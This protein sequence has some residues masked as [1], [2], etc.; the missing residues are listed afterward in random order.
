MKYGVMIYESTSNIG[1]DIQSYAA[2]RFLPRIDTVIDR[3]KMDGFCLRNKVDE[4][5]TVIMNGWYMHRK[6]N[7]PPSPLINPLYLSMHITEYD[8]LDIGYRF[9]D[10][11]GGDYLRQFEPIGARDE[12]TLA[13]LKEKGIEAYLSGCL[14]LTLALPD[15]GERG[16]EVILTDVNKADAAALIKQFPNENWQ[17]VSHTID[18]EATRQKSL[19]ERFEAV[20]ALLKRYQRAKCV[21]TERLHCALPCLALGTPVLLL[22][23]NDNLDRMS[24]FLPLLHN[25]RIGE[26]DACSTVFNIAS[27]PENSTAYLKIRSELEDRCRAFIRDAESNYR[28]SICFPSEDVIAW[29]KNLMRDSELTYFTKISRIQESIRKKDK[30]LTDIKKSVAFRL[31]TDIA[32]PWRLVRD[33]VKKYRRQF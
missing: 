32:K 9:L 31:G 22:W 6:F 17:K 1:D 10:G 7:W 25:M 21:V 13:L 30:E 4:P 33:R 16:D 8:F 28:P 24:S 12:S 3:E 27:P 15:Q 14:T 19:D 11:L 26:T 29:Q 18:P 2:K 23:E 5:V 20:E